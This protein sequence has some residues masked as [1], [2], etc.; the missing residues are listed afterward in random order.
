MAQEDLFLEELNVVSGQKVA[1]HSHSSAYEDESEVKGMQ[2]DLMSLC[3]RLMKNCNLCENKEILSRAQ[4]GV[5]DVLGIFSTQKRK[6]SA[7]EGDELGANSVVKAQRRFF[8]TK[9]RFFAAIPQESLPG[10]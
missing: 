7:L 2:E 1:N 4:D 5:R 9:R 10:C 8:A 3:H 6:Y